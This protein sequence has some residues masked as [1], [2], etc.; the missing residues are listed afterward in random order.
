MPCDHQPVACIHS[1]L[2]HYM[3]MP[4]LPRAVPKVACERSN[5]MLDRRLVGHGKRGHARPD[6]AVKLELGPSP[7]R[8]G[9]QVD[10]IRWEQ[11]CA[12]R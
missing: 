12:H 10:Q 3:A 8:R 1:C 5:G 2:G 9:E 7:T 11:E 6:F 4:A